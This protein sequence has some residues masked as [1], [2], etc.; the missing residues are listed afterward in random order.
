[1]LNSEEKKNSN[2][3]LSKQ[4]FLNETNN[5]NPP[6]PLQV[7]WSVPNIVCKD[8][9]LHEGLYMV[10]LDLWC[11]MSLSTL[12]QLYCGSQFCWWR[13]PEYPEKT[14]VL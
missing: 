9:S 11:L 6:S 2:S 10:G 8:V 14:T 4:N 3:L 12:F 5:H 1:M 13:K 7:K